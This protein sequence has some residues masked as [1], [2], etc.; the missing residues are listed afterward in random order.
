MKKI[1]F[2]IIG[3][4]KIA[5]KNHIPGLLKNAKDAEIVALYDVKQQKARDRA[6]QYGLKV[7]FCRSE[8]EI[9]AAPDVDAV[10]IATPNSCHYPQTLHALKAGKYVLV[11]KPMS[12][13]P[14][15]AD[16]MI[17]LSLKQGLVLQVNQSMRFNRLMNGVHDLV[18]GGLLGDVINFRCQ[19]AS[20]STPNKR[21]SIGADWFVDPKFEGSLVGDI[22]VHMADLLQW[23]VGPVKRIMAITRKRENK[24]E[25]NL[26]AL[27][28][29][30]NG[31]TGIL[32]QSWTY[33]SGFW[34]QEIYG[35]KGT[36]RKIAGGC[37]FIPAGKETASTVYSAESFPE[38]PNSQAAFIRAIRTGDRTAWTA[39]RQAIALV[40]AIRESSASGQAEVPRNRKK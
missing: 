21:W 12:F 22:A 34:A 40:T 26:V 16:E 28:D 38:Q 36:L 9:L 24:V 2:G 10:I 30:A 3:C 37:E 20:D 32:E 14:E 17:D 35:T 15:Q 29:F 1:R 39:G 6:E 18:A 31:A 19:R 33:P 27:L 4:G 13:D 23:T 7:K 8:K 11:E 5:E 25:D